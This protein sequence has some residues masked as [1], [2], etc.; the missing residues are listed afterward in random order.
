M[1]VLL[2]FLLKHIYVLCVFL[3]P[4]STVLFN[5]YVSTIETIIRWSDGECTGSSNC[6][7]QIQQNPYFVLLTEEVVG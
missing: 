3:T 1:Q 5:A 2:H 6:L 4:K 7:S